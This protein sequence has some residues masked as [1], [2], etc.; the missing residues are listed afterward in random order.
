[1]NLL[2]NFIMRDIHTIHTVPMSSIG[3]DGLLGQK[4]L[5]KEGGG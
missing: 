5:L 4:M 3:C 2:K 1:M